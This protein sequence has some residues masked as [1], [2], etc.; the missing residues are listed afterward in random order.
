MEPIHSKGD[1]LIQKALSDFSEDIPLEV[2][3]IKQDGTL[4]SVIQRGAT[5]NLKAKI[6][7]NHTEAQDSMFGLEELT[8]RYVEEMQAGILTPR[9]DIGSEK[10]TL[11]QENTIK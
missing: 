8:A 5:P 6:E 4:P 9:S 11:S 1:E 10:K 3:K 7:E 2:Q